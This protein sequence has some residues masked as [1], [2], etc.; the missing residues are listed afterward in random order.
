MR[1]EQSACVTLDIL[2]KLMK[3][4]QC[5]SHAVQEKWRHEEHWHAQSVLLGQFP[6]QIRVS[7]NVQKIHSNKAMIAKYA[8][9]FFHRQ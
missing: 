3:R 6:T 9:V 5:A 1:R 4:R 2:L 7:A 8:R